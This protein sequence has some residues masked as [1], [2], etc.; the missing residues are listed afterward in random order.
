M[1]NKF[2]IY[3]LI[4]GALLMACKHKKPANYNRADTVVNK[5]D[6]EVKLPAPYETKAVKNYCDVIGWPKGKTPVAPPGFSVSLYAD[7]LDNPR[8]I[9]VASN[10]DVFVS[11]A[12]TEV[13]GLKKIGADIIGVSKSQH[14]GKSA[15]KILLFKDANGDGELSSLSAPALASAIAALPN[16]AA[17]G[18]TPVTQLLLETGLV[19]S[20]GEARR[21]IAQGGVYLNNVKVEDDTVTVGPHALAG[22]HAILRRGKK[23]LAGI[24]IVESL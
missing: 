22:W 4:A 2:I 8:N 23:T 12:N 20:L 1:K 7:G 18:D 9:Y 13:T 21:A 17:T 16:V 19:T 11:E 14:L 5:S 24:K 3:P 10:G 15:N 6:Q